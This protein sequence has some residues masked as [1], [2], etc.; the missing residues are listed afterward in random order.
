[1]RAVLDPFEDFGQQIGPYTLLKK[2]GEGG[3]G[4]VWMAEQ[5]HPIRRMVALKVMK[6]GIDS[7]Q[8]LSRFGAESQVLALMDHPNVAGVL[9]AGA[10][11]AGRPYFVM[12]V[13]DGLPITTFSDQ[14]QLSIPERLE[15]FVCVCH[16]IQHAH[17]KGI[18]HRDIKPS[19]VLVALY[20][21]RPVPK[22]IDFGIAKA[23]RHRLTP[24]TLLTEFGA[25]LG[26]LEYMSP[27]QA[28]MNQSDIDTR[29]DI[30][31]LGVLLYELITGTTPLMR[32]TLRGAAMQEVLGRIRQE[33]ACR[34]SVRLT[35]IGEPLVRIAAQRKAEPA[36]LP[37][38][39]RGDLDTICAKCLEK[40][41]AKRYPTAK[42]LAEDLVRFLNKESIHARPIGTAE[43]LQRWVRRNPAPTAL[44]V[45][46][47][48]GLSAAL[49]MLGILFRMHGDLEITRRSL[50]I[51]LADSLG[52]RSMNK[53]YME[54]RSET[55]AAM[56][57]GRITRA[58]DDHLRLILAVPM[59]QSYEETAL[60]YAKLVPYLEDSMGRSLGRVVRLNL[61]V[62]EKLSA[63]SLA[64]D[65]PD[66][67]HI[68]PLVYLEA[69]RA[70]H[71]FPPIVRPSAASYRCYIVSRSGAGLE[72]LS[73]LR[74]RSLMFVEKSSPVTLLAK[75]FLVQNGFRE[76]DFS[77]CDYTPEPRRGNLV[78]GG[79]LSTRSV[80][81]EKVIQGQHDA[82][83]VLERQLVQSQHRANLVVLGSFQSPDSFWV[84]TPQTD[85]R[86]VSAFQHAMQRLTNPGILTSLPDVPVRPSAFVRALPSDFQGLDLAWESAA[87]FDAIDSRKP[88]VR[89][90]APYE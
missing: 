60:Q 75:S 49:V 70:G 82:A 90:K 71:T 19:N 36:R 88:E 58:P 53:E 6:H 32:E 81:L 29:S 42:H 83:V 48:L 76:G 31:S 8:V 13:V 63:G 34:P 43:R 35:G 20:D 21:G 18:I 12:E 62:Y 30:Y 28:E 3:M 87:H 77:E 33:D 78:P 47:V 54:I 65:K 10:T 69:L 26:T 59:Q 5:I 37:K 56:H 24:D 67:V 11:E 68:N 79:Y 72:R 9:D 38:L 64:V 46:L 22:V 51:A 15:L 89:Q 57:G 14:Q 84:T 1:M 80:A 40:T 52:E 27:E 44:I 85:Q 86:L 74:G 55:L 50:G 7:R 25:L 16:A 73:D 41:P 4:T 17:Q 66:F 45:T 39:L 61:R 2:L 23:T